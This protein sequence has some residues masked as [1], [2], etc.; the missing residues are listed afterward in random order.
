MADDK[1]RIVKYD[2]K[3]NLYI[4]GTFTLT[5]HKEGEKAEKINRPMLFDISLH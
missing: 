4:K 2:E 1:D 5:T 3:T